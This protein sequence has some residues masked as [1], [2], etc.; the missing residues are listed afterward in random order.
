MRNIW[1]VVIAN[2]RKAK[3]Q[4]I[5]L[6]FVVFVAAALL[7]IALLLMLC[8]GDFFEERARALNAP[9]Y[10]FVE[11]KRLYSE[12]QIDYLDDY[13]GVTEVEIDTAYYFPA[14]FSFNDGVTPGHI[15]FQSTA[16]HSDMDSLTLIEGRNALADN[17]ICLPYL[18]ETG[19]YELD[20][21]IE[22][23]SPHGTLTYKISGFYEEV[24]LGSIYNQTYQV[25]IANSAYKELT[26]KTKDEFIVL[27]VQMEDSL[28]SE[29]LNRDFCKEFLFETSYDGS[30]LLRNLSLDWSRV[31]LSRTYMSTITSAVLMISAVLIVVISLLLIRFRIR[32]S[33]EE[34]MTNIGSLKAAGY[35]GTQV[36]LATVLQFSGT[37]LVGTLIGIGV[38]YIVLPA[39]SQ[40]LEQQTALQWHQ[41]FDLVCFALTLL[42]ILSTVLVVTLVSARKMRALPPLIALRL[43]LSTHTFQRNHFPLQSS[44]GPLSW[45]LALKRITQSLWQ[46]GMVFIVITALSFAAVASVTIYDNLGNRSDSFAKLLFGEIPDAGFF[47]KTPQYAEDVFKFIKEDSSVRKV[48]YHQNAN[49][50]INDTPVIASVTEDFSQY[51]GTLLYKGRYPKHENEVCIASS[52]ISVGNLK[53]GDTIT[54]TGW[55]TSKEYLVVGLIQTVSNNGLACA[56]TAEGVLRMQPSFE[57]FEMYVY[58][59]DTDN[60]AEFVDKIVANHGDSIALSIDYNEFMDVQLGTYSK[61]FFWVALVLVIVTTLLV[62]LVLY[63][64]LKTVI[65]RRWRE[66]G[67][68]KSIGFTTLQLMNQLALYI[69]P[70]IVLGTVAGGLLGTFGFNPLFVLI[71]GNMGIMTASMPVTLGPTIVVCVLLIILSYLFVMAI[72]RKIRKVSVRTLIVE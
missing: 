46:M 63:L 10:L 69:M 53:I 3:G 39:V 14:D 47:A 45:L 72:T 19:G 2:L 42:I 4:S 27:R 26:S 9:H 35:T 58:L 54:I 12:R 36:L 6:L 44:R 43:G 22:F 64:L 31:K 33:I 70:V 20:D 41:G 23:L 18:F 28:Q 52:L 7:N 40:V 1:L 21:E 16:T 5:S 38:S 8:F 34:N 29:A 50:M 56:L 57:F 68:Q 17:E 55:G 15:L 59:H 60:S 71:A 30:G 61:I 13:P 66:F 62:F 24:M 25:Y 37:A 65:L 49:V 11:E 67:I 51:E 48:F 32:N